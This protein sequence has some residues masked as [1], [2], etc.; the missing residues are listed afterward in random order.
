MTNHTVP[1]PHG[2]APSCASGHS[3]RRPIAGSNRAA[4]N[5]SLRQLSRSGSVGSAQSLATSTGVVR[6]A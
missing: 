3:T 4:S 5:N 2:S 6:R 1:V